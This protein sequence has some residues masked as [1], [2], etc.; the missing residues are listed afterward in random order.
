MAK[1]ATYIVTCRRQKMLFIKFEKR[2]SDLCDFNARVNCFYS[3]CPYI[4]LFFSSV[5]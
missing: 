3:K 4:M 5:T 1:T 2:N